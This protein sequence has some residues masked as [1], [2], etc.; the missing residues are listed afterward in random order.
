VPVALVAFGV[1]V[2]VAQ[3]DRSSAGDP[4]VKEAAASAALLGKCLPR[5]GST[6]SSQ[7]VACTSPKA[8]VRIVEVLPPGSPLCPTGT[9]GIELPYPG[10]TSPHVECAKP[11]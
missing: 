9:V 4:A 1:I 11:L 7:P 10:V 6:Y 8:A 5:S 2:A 3:A